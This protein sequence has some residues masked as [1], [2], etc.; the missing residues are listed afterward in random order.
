MANVLIL[1]R[2]LPKRELGD[3]INFVFSLSSQMKIF[4][5]SYTHVH[6]AYSFHNRLFGLNEDA[7]GFR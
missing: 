7:F 3:Y 5:K 1:P 4:D 2:R 6:F